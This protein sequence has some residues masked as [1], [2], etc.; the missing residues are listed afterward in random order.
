MAEMDHEMV[1]ILKTNARRMGSLARL[2]ALHSS[3]A[4]ESTFKKNG[5]SPRQINI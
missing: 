1:L 4:S 2:V 3:T 5:S